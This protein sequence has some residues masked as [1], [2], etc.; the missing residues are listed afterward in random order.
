MESHHIKH[1]V[2]GG[3]DEA[4]NRRGLCTACHDH[5]HAKEQVERAIERELERLE[6]LYKRLAH[7]EALNTPERISEEQAYQSYF[8]TFGEFVPPSTRCGRQ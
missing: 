5:Q 7:I 4:A 3:S 2:D 8:N 6:I 1:K